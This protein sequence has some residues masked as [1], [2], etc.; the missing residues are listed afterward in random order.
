MASL[1]VVTGPEA[2]AVFN[3]VGFFVARIDGSHHTMKREGHPY[4][5]TVPVHG[6]KAVK[7]GTLRSLIR[8]ADM[9]VEQFIEIL[10]DT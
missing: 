3:R 10:E 2:I 7:S 1:P 6:K 4:V 8:K 5:L 9:T